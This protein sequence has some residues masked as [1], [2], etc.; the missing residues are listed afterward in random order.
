[1]RPRILFVMSRHNSRALYKISSML[2]DIGTMVEIDAIEPPNG[3]ITP[4][5]QQHLD[6]LLSSIGKPDFAVYCCHN[7]NP[8]MRYFQERLDV[9]FGN[10]DIEHDLYSDKYEISPKA[11]HLGAFAFT[12]PQERYLIKQGRKYW[13]ACWYKHDAVEWE[14][15][16][17]QAERN[18]IIFDAEHLGLRDR[19][20]M[21]GHLFDDVYLKPAHP[22]NETPLS[23]SCMVNF[24]AWDDSL[25]THEI[26]MKALF[27]FSRESSA[28]VEALFVDRIPVLY[29][30]DGKSEQDGFVSE[31]TEEP[32][33]DVLSKVMVK[34]Q[35]IAGRKM[36]AVTH[37]GDIM[38]K[39]TRLQN[40]LDYR[41]YALRLMRDQWDIG[42]TMQVR[43]ILKADIER[44]WNENSC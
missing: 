23:R 24:D 9:R 3:I 26:G 37:T 20:F 8:A 4:D 10:Y 39:I 6:K 43:D 35:F 22:A 2:D 15:V 1:M 12:L 33:D 21:H 29:F 31:I 42:A 13:P 41:R 27:W 44:I 30:P 7:G 28:I 19:P 32:F 36:L 25:S 5:I 38:H 34:S 18:A 14:G 40:D 17:L 16:S 11:K